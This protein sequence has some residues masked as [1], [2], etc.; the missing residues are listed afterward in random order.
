MTI[1]H[2]E[3]STN[4]CSVAVSH[5]GKCIFELS[6]SDLNHATM[7]SPFIEKAL[8]KTK[9]ENLKLDAVAVSGGPGSYTGLRIGVSTAKGLCYGLNIPLISVPTLQVLAQG[10]LVQQKIEEDAMLCPMIDARR[11]EVYMAH[12]TPT[13]ELKE[14]VYAEIIT[15][16]SFEELLAAGKVYFFGNGAEKCKSTLTHPNAI[17]IDNVEVLAKNMISAA[18]KKFLEKDFADVAY[19]EPFY[20][21]EFQ[22]TTPKKLF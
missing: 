17:F 10:A 15:E 5:A 13:L 18:E 2:I 4:V 20:L 22:A 14:D 8:E 19:F 12:Y 7:L 21:K 9:A 16:N 11:M 6:N 1:L 3:T